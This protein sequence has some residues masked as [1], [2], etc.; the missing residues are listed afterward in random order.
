MKQ[1]Y[2]KTI[3]EWRE[4][5]TQHHR[6]V[7]EIWLVFYKKS[8]SEQTLD[9]AQA[10]DEALCYGWIDSLIKKIDAEKYVRKFTPRHEVSKWSAINKKRVLE[11]IAEGRMTPPGQDV[12]DA[13]HANGCWNKAD[14][15]LLVA[16]DMPDIFQQA[17]HLHPAAQRHFDQL[18]ASEKKRYIIWIA[19][20][21]RPETQ[22]R[23][24]EEA[25][26]LLKKGE[27][28]GLK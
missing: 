22:N 10:L 25:I 21:K 13:A 19:M 18:P 23:R 24:T 26:R 2:C 1:L 15:P 27:K 20:A 28:L 5:L 14:R 9:Y 11:L 3:Q 4:W 8:G 17:L 12:V 6:T 7:A 16:V